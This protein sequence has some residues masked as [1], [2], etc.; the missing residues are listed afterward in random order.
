MTPSRTPRCHH[1]PTTID[2]HAL[3]T[4]TPKAARARMVRLLRDRWRGVTVTVLLQSASTIA[5]L[6]GPALVGVVVDAVANDSPNAESTVDRAAIAYA[7]LA[8]AGCG[9]PLLR[10]GARCGRGRGRARRD[11]DRGVRPR[12]RGAGRPG[13]TRRHRR[14]REPRDQR[15]HDP[16]RRGAQFDSHRAPCRS[17]RSRSPWSPCWCSMCDLPAIALITAIPITLVAGQWY[18][19]RA[20]SLYRR[21]RER[22]AALGAGLHES[23]QGA[24]VLAGFR[25]GSRTRRGL[26]RRGRI[27]VDAEMATTSARNRMRPGISLA[28][29]VSLVAVMAAGAALVDNG[30]IE[31]GTL[32]AAA[33]YLVQLFN[34]V[35][36]LL[37][38]T[39]QMQ[40][41]TASFARLVGSHPASGRPTGR[42]GLGAP[43]ALDHRGRCQRRRR[44]VRL[45]RRHARARRHQPPHRAGRA[46]GDRRAERRGQDHARQD[47]RRA[48]AH[49]PR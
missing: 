12:A 49:Q 11:A 38:Q 36:T 23:Y 10:R 8:I 34:P 48:P 7:V 30:S 4:A 40:R 31:I 28:Q 15:H 17:R 41:S 27:T 46:S 32:S 3:P 1:L 39:D 37:E 26:A 25:A 43:A 44:G 18:F 6:A 2:D 22:H 9:P 42:E 24:S 47:H 21:E 33:L 35:A 29:A 20:H 13:R 14:P 19:R 5:T 45:R 16:R